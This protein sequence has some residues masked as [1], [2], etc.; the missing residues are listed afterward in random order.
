MNFPPKENGL[1]SSSYQMPKIPLGKEAREADM[2][3]FFGSPAH[4][5]GRFRGC[6]GTSMSFLFLVCRMGGGAIVFIALA[7]TN[8]VCKWHL[9]EPQSTITCS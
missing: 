6:Q 3:P 2:G 4:L 5:T 7:R 8:E 9:I 1:L